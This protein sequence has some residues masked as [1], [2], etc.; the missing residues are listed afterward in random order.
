[1]SI[2]CAN[3]VGSIQV[4]LGSQMCVFHNEL[5]FKTNQHFCCL[6]TKKIVLGHNLSLTFWIVYKNEIAL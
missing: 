3:Y 6:T 4:F 5:L 1:M 2:F